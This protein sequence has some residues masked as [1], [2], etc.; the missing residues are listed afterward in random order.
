MQRSS[1]VRV[2]EGIQYGQAGI[3]YEVGKGSKSTRALMADVYLPMNETGG[4]RPALILAFGGAFQRG[5][6]K[7]DVVGEPPHR[8]TA[9]AE[10]CRK[11]AQRGYVCFSI[12]YRLMPEAPDP[13]VTATW[14]EG[15]AVN[16]ERANFVRGLLGLPA[17]TQQ[18]MIDAIEAGTDDISLA[19]EYVRDNAADFSIDPKRLVVGGF[20]AGATIAINATYAQELPVAA[21]VSISGRMTLS[22]AEAYVHE[23]LRQPALFMS[24]GENDLPGTLEYL[25]PRTHYLKRLGLKHRVVHVSGGT[26]FYPSTSR[27]TFQNGTITDLESAIAAFL[28]EV[29]T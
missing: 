24:F 5:T 17:C 14:I 27:V 18:M 26:H 23:P 19:V 1:L 9:I 21:V 20:S 28:D 4:L 12:D 13:G 11:F 25:Q 16:V 3:G 8:N 29:L 22:S 2:I 7:D 15:T 6:R 10:Y